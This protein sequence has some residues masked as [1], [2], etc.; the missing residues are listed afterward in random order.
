MR[1]E[2]KESM[3]NKKTKQ[4]QEMSEE[5]GTQAGEIHDLKDM[6]DVK[7]RKVNVLQK[8]V[9]SQTIES[10]VLQQLRFLSENNLG[11][12]DEICDVKGILVMRNLLC[13]HNLGGV[14]K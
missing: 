7:E 5:K 12:V 6:L 2:E 3:L 14:S 8:K 13:L 4:I 1:L 11:V 10:S 9:G